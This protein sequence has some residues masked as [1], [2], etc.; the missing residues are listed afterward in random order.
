M[1][2]EQQMEMVIEEL[3]NLANGAAEEGE[4]EVKDAFRWAIAIL[5]DREKERLALRDE[6]AG[7]AITLFPL[8]R[9]DVLNM[10]NGGLPDHEAVAHFCYSLADAM[11]EARKK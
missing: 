7:M 5:E 8:T 1:R 9:G 10:E 6:F 2:S 11:L 4:T 3:A